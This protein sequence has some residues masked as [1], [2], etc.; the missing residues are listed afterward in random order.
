MNHAAVR[1]TLPQP[2]SLIIAS[3]NRAHMLIETVESILQGTCV[4]NEIIIIDQSDQPNPTLASATA[5][6]V[7]AI[8]Y[9][10]SRTVGLSRAN[11]LAVARAQHDLLVFTHDDVRVTPT[12][13][14]TLVAALVQAGPRAVVTGRILAS[15]PKRAGTFAPTLRT[16]TQPARYHGRIGK[17]V[18]KPLN[19][20]M[21]R[22]ALHEV[23]GFDVRLGPGTSFPG[24]EDSDLGFRLLEAGYQ[25]VY[26]PEA[27]VYH[28]AWR[29]ERE[30]LPLRW[31]YGLAQGAFYAKHLQLRDRYML[32]R[33]AL[34]ANHRV[35]RFPGRL[36]REGRRG[37][38]DPLFIIGNVIGATRWFL[39]GQT[40]A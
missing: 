37:L 16:A 26:V 38:G 6:G 8:R 4:P 7:C 9:Q 12:W 19:M 21:W 39:S 29:A 13:L 28:R 22:A 27:L 3:R 15:E 17:D 31:R 1:H 5:D 32:R 14:G 10:W 25:I 33:F 24:A 2:V 40:T 18:L 36:W 11:N 30:Y 34:D 35:R 20:A 23:G